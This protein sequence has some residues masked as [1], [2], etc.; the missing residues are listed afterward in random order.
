M[1]L[2]GLGRVRLV[3]VG[4][5]IREFDLDRRLGDPI[6]VDPHALD[7]SA[8]GPSDPMSTSQCDD[9]ACLA[10]IANEPL[11]FS[12]TSGR[13]CSPAP[14]VQ[15]WAA[16]RSGH[17]L[18]R[19]TALKLDQMQRRG[20]VIRYRHPSVSTQAR[21]S[22]TKPFDDTNGRL[23]KWRP[24]QS[25]TVAKAASPRGHASGRIPTGRRP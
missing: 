4:R 18:Q 19:G 24:D 10:C 2:P 16:G 21:P 23:I 11:E 6:A 12:L 15:M 7:R 22:A 14:D 5:R 13:S 1:S 8:T 9:G 25:L 20:A 17:K 3:I